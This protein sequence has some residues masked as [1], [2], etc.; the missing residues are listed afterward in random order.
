AAVAQVRAPVDHSRRPALQDEMGRADARHRRDP[1]PGG[2]RAAGPEK[3]HGGPLFEVHRLAEADAL[4]EAPEV[5]APVGED[6]PREVVVAAS[7]EP[8]A[9]PAPQPAP[10]PEDL[11]GGSRAQTP[12]GPGPS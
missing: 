7:R 3:A 5:G 1:R 2:R 10:R 6:V 8:R 11:Y 9:E 12:G 4:G